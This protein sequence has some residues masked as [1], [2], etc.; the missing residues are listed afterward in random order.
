MYGL[1]VEPNRH[2]I[3]SVGAVQGHNIR[4]PLASTHQRT[5]DVVPGFILTRRADLYS[6]CIAV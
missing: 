4:L 5:L 6:R 3:A 2:S 1:G